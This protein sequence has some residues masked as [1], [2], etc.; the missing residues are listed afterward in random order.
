MTLELSKVP[1]NFAMDRRRRERKRLLPRSAT[2]RTAAYARLLRISYRTSKQF[3]QP[4]F[5][6][7]AGYVWARFS[8]PDWL[9]ELLDK[10][11]ELHRLTFRMPISSRLRRQPPAPPMEILDDPIPYDDSIL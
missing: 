4:W 5:E 6:P 2:E 8:D 9:F 7:R 10:F 1:S 3:G 11:P